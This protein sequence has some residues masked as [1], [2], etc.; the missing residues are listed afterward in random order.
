MAF[1]LDATAFAFPP[2]SRFRLDLAGSDFSSS[3]PPPSAGTLEV[4]RSASRLLLPV[5]A[6]S[7]LEPPTFAPGLPSPHHPD[8]VLWEVRHDVIADERRVVIDHGGVRGQG[9]SGVEIL[10]SYGGEVGVRG[11]EPGI[12]WARGGTTYE[13]AWPEVAVRSRVPR[14]PPDGRL[15][16]VP[17]ARAQGVRERRADRGAELG[18]DR[19][20]PPAIAAPSL[21]PRWRS[22]STRPPSRSSIPTAARSACPS[23]GMIR[24]TMGERSAGD[25]TP[26][27]G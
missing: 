16:L 25:G 12:A 27:H 26:E 4:D 7:T 15:H 24:S 23:D 9:A 22:T 18:T 14:H 10:D 1:D 13:L 21:P 5:V 2:G 20:T 19:G 17:R 6:P 11:A 3:W 8:R